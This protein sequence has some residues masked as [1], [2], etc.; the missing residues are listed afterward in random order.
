MFD[1]RLGYVMLF[2]SRT[3]RVLNSAES[4]QII[5]HLFHSPVISISYNNVVSLKSFYRY[6]I[7]HLL[8]ISNLLVIIRLN[9]VFFSYSDTHSIRQSSQFSFE[10]IVTFGSMTISPRNILFE[11]K[12]VYFYNSFWCLP[13]D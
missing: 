13:A 7:L 2:A 1:Y 11:I 8:T 9:C 4:V 3:L 10:K 5:R 6:S 12:S